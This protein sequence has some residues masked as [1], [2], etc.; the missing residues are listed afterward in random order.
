MPS[1]FRVVVLVCMCI[2]S[3]VEAQSPVQWRLADGGNGHWYAVVPRSVWM[4][5]AGFA[6]GHLLILESAAEAD[7]V[8]ANVTGTPAYWSQ[9]GN[10]L[11]GPGIGLGNYCLSQFRWVDGTSPLFTRWAVGQPATSCGSVVYF[12]PNASSGPQPTWGTT[13]TVIGWGQDPEWLAMEWSTDC[14]ADGV[15]DFGQ[16]QA[17]TVGDIDADGIADDCDGPWQWRVEDGGNGHWYELQNTF[18]PIAE[19]QAAAVA[20]GG[21][22]A[23]LT[24]AGEDAFVDQKLSRITLA[25]PY[26]DVLLGG[27]KTNGVWS[28]ITGEPWGGFQDFHTTFPTAGQNLSLRI[29]ARLDTAWFG[30]YMRWDGFGLSMALPPLFE[31]SADCNGDGVVDYGQIL[32]GQLPDVNS[33]G[34]PDGCEQPACSDV[35]L[36]ADGYVNGL[37]LGILLGQWGT[38]STAATADF[39]KDGAV[40]GFDLGCL[41]L[42]WGRCDA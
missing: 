32:Q 10:R 19:A 24:S 7:W 31:W 6:G 21:H 41:L 8:F 11:V 2:V 40:D 34:V 14:G 33:N 1:A 4:E 18:M 17:G 16:I 3:S 12:A 5:R 37:D 38:A 22:L 26:I 15:V 36:V 25:S 27:I 20:E 13:Y 35:D 23:T 9:I 39:D 42:H 30:Q 29:V 28:W